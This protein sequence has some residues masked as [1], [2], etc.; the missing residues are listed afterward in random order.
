[1]APQNLRIRDIYAENFDPVLM[2]ERFEVFNNPV[3]NRASAQEYAA[4]L[5]WTEA[6]IFVYPT[7]WYGLSAIP[8]DAP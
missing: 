4:D 7:W 2:R 6:L 3:L 5:D 1:M 8:N